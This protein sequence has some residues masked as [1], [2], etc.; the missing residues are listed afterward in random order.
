VGA[1]IAFVLL[2]AN[3]QPQA[4]LAER[5]NPER[6]SEAPEGRREEKRAGKVFL[7]DAITTRTEGS[8]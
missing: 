3:H 8:S 2:A 7:E 4:P 5:K 1:T 6:H